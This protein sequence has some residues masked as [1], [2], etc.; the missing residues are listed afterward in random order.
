MKQTFTYLLLS[1]SLVL[2]CMFLSNTKTV[3]QENKTFITN[4]SIKITTYPN[5]TDSK[6]YI[7]LS[8]A[9][10]GQVDRVEIVNVIGKKLK[11]QQLIDKNTTEIMFNNLSD[12]PVGIHMIIVRDEYGKILQ[13]SK[14]MI[15]R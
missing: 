7:K 14:F 2:S 3:A 9:L 12:L 5:P 11:E 4:E 1:F 13:S 8:Q 15:N 10:K 6:L